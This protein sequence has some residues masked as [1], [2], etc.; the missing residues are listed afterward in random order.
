MCANWDRYRALPEIVDP[1][2]VLVLLDAHVHVGRLEVELVRGPVP[3]QHAGQHA[4]AAR[5]H[6]D[7][8]DGVVVVHTE[9]GR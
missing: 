5:L 2:L 4:R 3:A 8:R 7:P 9:P 6:V 1:S